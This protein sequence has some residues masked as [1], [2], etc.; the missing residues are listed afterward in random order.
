MTSFGEVLFLSEIGE[1]GPQ[2]VGRSVRTLGRLQKAEFASNTAEIALDGVALRVRTDL[3]GPDFPLVDGH[4]YEF[5]GEIE[6]P[7]APA[8]AAA[9]A[10]AQNVSGVQLLARIGRDVEGKDVELFR[11]AILLRRQFLQDFGRG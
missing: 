7:A 5:L 6:R 10:A 11:Q 1:M 2:L 4:L 3:L 8:A 9:A